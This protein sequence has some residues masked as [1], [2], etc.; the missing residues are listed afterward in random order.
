[1]GYNNRGDA[2]GEA[3]RI[4]E[5]NRSSDKEKSEG[6]YEKAAEKLGKKFLA[7]A[8]KHSQDD[9]IIYNSQSH[10]YAINCV[11]DLKKYDKKLQARVSF[12]DVAVNIDNKRINANARYLGHSYATVDRNVNTKTEHANSGS[13]NIS[14]TSVGYSVTPN[15]YSYTSKTE[16]YSVSGGDGITLEKETVHLTCKAVKVGTAA[17]VSEKE[18]TLSADWANYIANLDYQKKKNRVSR[19]ICYFRNLLDL[20]PIIITLISFAL[21]DFEAISVVFGFKKNIEWIR[22]IDN[23]IF[24]DVKILV[25]IQCSLIGVQILCGFLSSII[26]KSKSK[27]DGDNFKWKRNDNEVGLLE[28]IIYFVVMSVALLLLGHRDMLGDMTNS[29]LFRIIEISIIVVLFNGL[30]F[31]RVPTIRTFIRMAVALFDNDNFRRWRRVCDSMERNAN[32]NKF[33]ENTKLIKDIKSYTVS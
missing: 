5:A 14:A 7:F 29:I 21:A 23:A 20:F 2:Q 28:L 9:I 26:N 4:N 12:S 33:A 8:K 30:M 16:D 27:L 17:A 3:D 13:Y 19:W 18:K 1:M 15:T 24:R 6:A 32:P 25:I 22:I 11:K 10:Y 31:F